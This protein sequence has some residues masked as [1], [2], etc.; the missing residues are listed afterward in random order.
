MQGQEHLSRK[1]GPLGKHLAA[2]LF[3]FDK[4]DGAGPLAG[5]IADGAGNLYG[6]T[7][8]GGAHDD[9]V[10]FELTP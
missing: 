6:A 4:S 3:S 5:L 9:G 10:V 8:R 1:P 7:K 2:V